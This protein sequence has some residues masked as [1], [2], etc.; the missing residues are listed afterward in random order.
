MAI[1]S[2]KLL[3]PVSQTRVYEVGKKDG[4]PVNLTLIFEAVSSTKNNV[5]LKMTGTSRSLDWET[6]KGIQ[7]FITPLQGSSK[8][9]EITPSIFKGDEWDKMLKGD[10]FEALRW[11]ARQLPDFDQKLIDSMRNLGFEVSRENLEE[12]LK[13]MRDVSNRLTVEKENP[14]DPKEKDTGTRTRETI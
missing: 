8:K 5:V 6:R 9:N 13:V 11:V 14:G 12:Y 10:A 4:N 1:K 2:S 7:S 3:E